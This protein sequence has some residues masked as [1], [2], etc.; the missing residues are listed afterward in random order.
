MLPK[1]EKLTPPTTF[2]HFLVGY[3][4]LPPSSF[5]SCELITL[6]WIKHSTTYVVRSL[7][8]RALTHC[9]IELVPQNLLYA[10]NHFFP[11][12]YFSIKGSTTCGKQ[13]LH[14]NFWILSQLGTSPLVTTIKKPMD[15]IYNSKWPKT[16][17]VKSTRIL[18][19]PTL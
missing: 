7:R 19:D 4:K 8:C 16:W 3:I 2:V 18:H 9:F 6:S 11:L 10:I 12:V 15:H 5:L 14:L 1:K 17:L 13:I